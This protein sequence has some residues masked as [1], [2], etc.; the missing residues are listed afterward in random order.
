MAFDVVDLIMVMATDVVHFVS[1]SVEHD[2]QS[3]RTNT[4]PVGGAVS[5]DCY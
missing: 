2:A 3:T 5:F 4:L 1:K